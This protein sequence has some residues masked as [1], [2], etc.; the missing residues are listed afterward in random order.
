MNHELAREVWQRLEQF[1]IDEPGASYPFSAR[2]AKEN[3]WSLGFARRVIEEYKRY[4][5]LC[6]ASGSVP[7]PSEHVD[8]AWHL[9]LT[10]T[11]SYWKA[12]CGE[13]LGRPIHHEPTRG[14][15]DEHRKHL[16]MYE[17]TLADYREFFGCEPPLDIWP[18]AAI[19]FGDDVEHQ[20]VNIRRNWI[21][22]KWILWPLTSRRSMKIAACVGLITVP[23]AALNPFD[24]HGP[25]F[26]TFYI[27]CYVLA[28]AAG[29][30]VRQI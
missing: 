1:E 7:C 27:I 17:Q 4:L 13:I 14:G 30:A 2:L 6:V 16:A 10:Y 9:H 18:P 22:P 12:L 20:R 28:V 19:R 5:L 24:W 21:I 8:Q 15:Q 29:L 26:I 11:R 23:L 3:G 25:T